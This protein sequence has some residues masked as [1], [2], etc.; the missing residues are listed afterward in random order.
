MFKK[1][2]KG[3][4]TSKAAAARILFSSSLLPAAL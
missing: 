4:R 1:A 3:K 2:E